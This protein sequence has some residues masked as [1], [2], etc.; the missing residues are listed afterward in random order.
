MARNKSEMPRNSSGHG[1]TVANKTE[2]DYVGKGKEV[3]VNDSG[4]SSCL[5]DVGFLSIYHPTVG[6]YLRYGTVGTVGTPIS[7]SS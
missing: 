6:T 3:L 1:L 7:P 4:A 2:T 5:D